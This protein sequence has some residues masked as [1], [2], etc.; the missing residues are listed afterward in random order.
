M[1]KSPIIKRKKV[2]K[3]RKEIENKKLE[4]S[5]KSWLQN[6]EVKTMATVVTGMDEAETDKYL[7]RVTDHQ[8]DT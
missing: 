4:L 3:V 2:E 6:S 1:T 5:M 8:S 7:E